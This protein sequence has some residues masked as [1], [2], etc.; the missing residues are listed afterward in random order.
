MKG[1]SRHSPLPEEECSVCSALHREIYAETCPADVEKKSIERNL[2][3]NLLREDR[4]DWLEAK[5]FPE[6]VFPHP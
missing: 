5:V 3:K 6:K 4:V 2:K 1:G